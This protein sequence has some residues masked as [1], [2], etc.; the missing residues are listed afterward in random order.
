MPAFFGI[1]RVVKLRGISG[2]GSQ[3]PLVTPA[4]FTGLEGAGIADQDY[5]Q[6]ATTGAGRFDGFIISLIGRIQTHRR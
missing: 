4:M 6:P 3:F 1:F 5:R 2:T